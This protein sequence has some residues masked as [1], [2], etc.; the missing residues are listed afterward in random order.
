[1][2]CS[3][4]TIMPRNNLT[5]WTNNRFC[6]TSLFLNTQAYNI[7][8]SCISRFTP[9][10]RKPPRNQYFRLW[11][12]W[13]RAWGDTVK[14]D[15]TV[16]N[17]GRTE[18]RKNFWSSVQAGIWPKTFWIPKGGDEPPLNTFWSSKTLTMLTSQLLGNS[19][20]ISLFKSTLLE[21]PV[22]ALQQFLI[23]GSVYILSLPFI[24]VMST[25]LLS[26]NAPYTIHSQG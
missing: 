19:T 21:N 15:T 17:R 11:T 1:M 14:R 13:G 23:H 22:F 16:S 2:K 8:V 7:I 25:P 9:F 24:K 4:Q 6:C 20:L 10:W 18:L 26:N 12:Y 3:H 5:I